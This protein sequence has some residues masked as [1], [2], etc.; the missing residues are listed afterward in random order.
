MD[1]VLCQFTV[2]DRWFD[3][4]LKML[5]GLKLR[6]LHRWSAIILAAFLILHIGNH[7]A[8]L[9]GQNWHVAFMAAAREIYRNRFVEP[10]LLLVILWQA[11]SGLTLL[12]RVRKQTRD[13]LGW[14]QQLS[15]LY[16]SVFLL[17]HVGAVLS[18]RLILGLD[19]DF[20]FAAAGFH[21]WPFIWFFAPYYFLAVLSLF[22]HAGCGLYWNLQTLTMRVRQSILAGFCIAGFTA[23][24]L[25]MLSL[26]GSLYPV[27]IP[28]AYR[29][30]YAY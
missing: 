13:V 24:L 25:I 15:G 11:V 2:G 17:I 29:A 3:E 21:V 10:L 30:T 14:M 19:T 22:V 20:R 8:G 4:S 12:W 28:H 9:A 23:G 1:L 16:L 5:N 6:N 7:L 26:A 27:D 18:G